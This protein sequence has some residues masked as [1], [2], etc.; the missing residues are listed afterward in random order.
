MAD[1]EVLAMCRPCGFC[2]KGNCTLSWVSSVE[3]RE[4]AQAGNCDDAKTADN[5]R[6]TNTVR[7]RIGGAWSW[8]ET[9]TKLT[10]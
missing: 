3:Q 1:K 4:R 10:Q 5:G 9:V 7:V 2:Q 6:L 8:A